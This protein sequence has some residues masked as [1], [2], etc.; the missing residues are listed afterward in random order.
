MQIVKDDG[1][2]TA[3]NSSDIDMDGNVARLDHDDTTRFGCFQSRLAFPLYE[4]LRTVWEYVRRLF[5]R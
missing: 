2:K 4:K 1:F 3:G 5:R